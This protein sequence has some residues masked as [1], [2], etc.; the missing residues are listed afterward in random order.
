MVFGF[1]Y[2]ANSSES[3]LLGILYKIKWQL[4]VEVLSVCLSVSDIM[5]EPNPLD[6]LSLKGIEKFESV[7][8]SDTSA[9]E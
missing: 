7:I 9:N 1:A 5:S 4:C 2:C 6:M 8:N 3:L